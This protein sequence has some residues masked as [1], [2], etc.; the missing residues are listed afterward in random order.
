VH[1]IGK[2]DIGNIP[3]D[4]GAILIVEFTRVLLQVLQHGRALGLASV[5]LLHHLSLATALAAWQYSQQ[6][7]LPHP[8]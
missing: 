1:Q 7:A 4:S 6:C 3:L 8:D 5:P 2:R